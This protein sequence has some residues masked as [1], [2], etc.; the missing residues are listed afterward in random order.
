MV[1]NQTDRT[2]NHPF[3]EHL[4]EI[5]HV[6]QFD[7][8]R[9]GPVFGNLIDPE[10]LAPLGPGKPN[11]SAFDALSALDGAA[12]DSAAAGHRDMAAGCVSGLWLLHD[13]LDESHT[14]SQGIDTPTGSYWHGIMHRREPDFGNSAYWFRRVG[15]HAIFP[16]L[17]D[18][19]SELAGSVEHDH[20]ADF[21]SE[22]P[23]WN[24]LAF[25]DLCQNAYD[26]GAN[27][28]LCRQI[29][30][31]E[32]FLLFDFCHEQAGISHY[33]ERRC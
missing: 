28:A 10:R 14:I 32:W 19:A 15:E 27:A 33:R 23:A 2:T 25:I 13:Y 30:R 20:S 6:F 18:D 4:L 3:T 11:R 17:C 22:Q 9:Y 26:G 29:A 5:P 8:D 7:P 1:G 16:A 21:L 12:T 31:Q 24:A